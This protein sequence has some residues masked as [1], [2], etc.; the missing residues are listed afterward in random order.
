MNPNPFRSKRSFGPPIPADLLEAP[1]RELFWSQADTDRVTEAQQ[2]IT[3]FLSAALAVEE[4][5]LFDDLY[6]QCAC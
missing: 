3:D 5:Q 4:I 6:E 2:R 1:L